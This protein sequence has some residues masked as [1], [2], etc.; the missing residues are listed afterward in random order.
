MIRCA[1]ALLLTLLLLVR[2]PVTSRAQEATP[3]SPDAAIT[4]EVLATIRLPATANPALPAIFDVWLW[5][6]T[7]GEELRFTT[8]DSSP[9]IAADVVLE[10]A[11][12]VESEGRLQV[13]R[14]TGLEE[15]PSGTDVTVRA[16]E[17]VIYVENQAAQT[18]RNTGD[19][20]SQ[21]LSFGV[22]SATPSTGVQVG[23]VGQ[24][25]WA[26]SGLAGQALTVR[27]ERLT[28]PPGASLPAFV[29][30]V[31]AP[32]ILAVADGVALRTIVSPGA[33]TPRPARAFGQDEVMWLR[34]LSEGDEWHVRN[35]EDRPLVLLQVTITRDPTVPP[36]AAT[37]T[38]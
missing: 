4:T 25:D 14:T 31:R 30:E 9:S 21:V 6:L 5:R 23:P 13:Q 1:F 35:D 24:E 12:T 20:A 29:S 28:L 16:G 22:F 18:L 17:A 3:V 37:P 26:R 32:R 2:V 8:E 36:A 11:Y 15:V 38:S 10:G 34:S 33:V 27:V 19:E 7:P